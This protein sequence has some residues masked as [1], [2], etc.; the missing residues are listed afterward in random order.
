MKK[1]LA[2]VFFLA[3]ALIS[4]AQFS[5]QYEVTRIIKKKGNH[6]TV[7]AVNMFDKT[8]SAILFYRWRGAPFTNK[9]SIRPGTIFTYHSNGIGI[10]KSRLTVNQ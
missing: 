6:I 1:I 2:L 3:A 7:A 5:K 4:H 9:T 8:D 10:R